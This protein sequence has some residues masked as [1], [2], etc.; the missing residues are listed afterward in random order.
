MLDSGIVLGSGAGFRSGLFIYARV[1]ALQGSAQVQGY[2]Y[3][4]VRFRAGL[5]QRG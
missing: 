5:Y 2:R 4:R 1:S 3:F